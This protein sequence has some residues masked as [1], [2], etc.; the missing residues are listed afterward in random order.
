MQGIWERLTLTLCLFYWITFCLLPHDINSVLLDASNEFILSPIHIWDWYFESGF[1]Q[2]DA[3][4]SNRSH[5]TT[6]AVFSKS[7]V[8]CCEFFLCL[9]ILAVTFSLFLFYAFLLYQFMLNFSE[10]VQSPPQSGFT[11]K[12]FISERKI[13]KSSGFIENSF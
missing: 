2:K 5:F 11:K 12:K 13:E 3:S 4:W 1:P 6:T 10:L 9:S 8:Y 7:P